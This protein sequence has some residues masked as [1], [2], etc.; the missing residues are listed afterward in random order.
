MTMAANPATRLG[1]GGRLAEA[2]PISAMQTA[3][4]NAAMN[5]SREMSCGGSGAGWPVAP[6]NRF[7]ADCVERR[8]AFR[9]SPGAIAENASVS[10]GALS[11]DCWERAFM[12]L[13]GPKAF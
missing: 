12:T 8:A 2:M 5:H 6:D 11:K 3:I 10:R 9:L 1:G 4:T 7:M 13:Y